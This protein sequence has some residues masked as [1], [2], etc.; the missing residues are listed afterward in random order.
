MSQQFKSENCFL[1]HTVHGC[2]KH[3]ERGQLPP[4]PPKKTF[5]SNHIT[6]FKP[7]TMH[8]IQN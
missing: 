8:V 2:M 5:C 3:G 1:V 6:A 4:L 7:G